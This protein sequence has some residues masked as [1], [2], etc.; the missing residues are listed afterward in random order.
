MCC[1]NLRYQQNAVSDSFGKFTHL[2]FSKRI[3][4]AAALSRS[5]PEVDEAPKDI[6][7]E[8]SRRETDASHGRNR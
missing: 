3:Y 5:R 4:W 2:D 7:K 8:T 6:F 1:E